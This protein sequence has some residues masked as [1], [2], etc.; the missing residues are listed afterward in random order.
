MKKSLINKLFIAVSIGVL[1]VNF[2]PRNFTKMAEA[3]SNINEVVDGKLT[4]NDVNKENVNLASY[5][6]EQNEGYVQVIEIDLELFAYPSLTLKKGIPVQFII[7]A[8]QE[9]LSWCNNKIIM[10]DFNLEK[11]LKV[12]KNIIEFTP[13]KAGEFI[14]NC[15]MGMI[16]A[17]ITVIDGD[18]VPIVEYRENIS[19]GGCCSLK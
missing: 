1:V 13:T 14:Y 2:L 7:N 9:N 4:F 19:V 16:G 5:N 10:P 11:E 3:T 8:S 17:N 18:I 12:G 15:W 6:L